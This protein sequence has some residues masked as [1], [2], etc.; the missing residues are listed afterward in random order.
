MPTLAVQEELPMRIKGFTLIELLIVV[1][2]VAILAAIALPSYQESV[3]KNRRAQAK[4]DMTELAQ[5][6]ERQYTVDRSYTNFA[7]PFTNSPRDPG[8][9]VAYIISAP[10]LAA[11]T[12]T[13]R[14]TPT[15]IQGA[16]RCGKLQLDQTGVKFHEKGDDETCGWGTVGP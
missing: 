3:R 13:L 15:S 7:L 1:V 16:D 12:Y 2:I 9:A 4:A 8:A 11:K 6:F 14:V 5:G 10:V